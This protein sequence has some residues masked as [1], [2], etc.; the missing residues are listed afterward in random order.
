M[1]EYAWPFS[2]IHK[3]GAI[4]IINNADELKA[5]NQKNGRW[6]D[7][8]KVHVFMWYDMENLRG[9]RVEVQNT[10]IVRDFFGKKVCFKDAERLMKWPAYHHY[11]KRMAQVRAIAA[12]GLP[13]PGTGCSKAGWKQNAPAK[14]NSGN[15]H[16]KRNIARA[17]YEAR[18][19]GVPNKLGNSVPENW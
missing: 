2:A 12:K 14:K 15:K 18:E 8:H 11:N 6:S 13:I 3:D 19:Y 5:F 10:W 17:I 4:E 9:E 7:N 16:K 1:K